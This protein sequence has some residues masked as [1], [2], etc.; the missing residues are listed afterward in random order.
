MG[1]NKN[2]F[3]GDKASLTSE[4][5]AFA[6]ELGLASSVPEDDFGFS[7]FA[8]DKA[9]K[10]LSKSAGG[11]TGG[12]APVGKKEEMGRPGQVGGRGND[13]MEEKKKKRQW[14]EG[15]GPRPGA[16]YSLS[17]NLYIT[18]SPIYTL[19]VPFIIFFIAIDFRLLCKL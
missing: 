6:S 16:F 10:K 9:S 2:K 5:A 13:E 17:H 11:G 7:D 3:K 15:V 4:V 18:L 12:K 8:P 19:M 1:K 14:N